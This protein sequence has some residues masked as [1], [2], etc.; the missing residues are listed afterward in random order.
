MLGCSQSAK[1][2]SSAQMAKLRQRWGSPPQSMV[3]ELAMGPGP[4]RYGSL[5]TEPLSLSFCNYHRDQILTFTC[6]VKARVSTGSKISGHSSET[7]NQPKKKK[8]KQTTKLLGKQEWQLSKVQQVQPVSPG[9]ACSIPVVTQ[10]C[11]FGQEDPVT[12][13]GHWLLLHCQIR[14]GVG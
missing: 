12:A 1:S 7:R 6:A 14:G 10:V 11:G 5:S 3:T 13:V 8:K 4:L 9:P 2:Y